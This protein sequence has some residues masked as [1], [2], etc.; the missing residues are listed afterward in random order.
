MLCVLQIEV[1]LLG[2]KSCCMHFYWYSSVPLKT[3]SVPR[4]SA[5]WFCAVAT[6][7]LYCCYRASV[8]FV[9]SFCTMNA[10]R[11]SLCNVARQGLL[12]Y[13]QECVSVSSASSVVNASAPRRDNGLATAWAVFLPRNTWKPRNFRCGEC[14]Y[15]H[16]LLLISVY[17]NKHRTNYFC[18]RLFCSVS[19]NS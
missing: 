19:V 5:E 17:P 18:D 2:D 13:A 9:Q 8:R 14:E 6:E 15:D 11:F 10:M 7:L 1:L 4:K 16:V 3:S 12:F